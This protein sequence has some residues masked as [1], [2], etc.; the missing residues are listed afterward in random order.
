MSTIL[1]AR[2]GNTFNS[3]DKVVRVGL[4]SDL[5]LS[6]SGSQQ[7]E[8]LGLYINQLHIPITAVFT[9]CLIR[10]IQTA[11]IALQTANIDIPIQQNSIFNEIDYGPD[12]GKTEEEVIARIGSNA[13]DE[14]DNQAIVPPDWQVNPQ[15]IINHWRYFADKIEHQ[16][17]GQT[18]LVVTSNGIARFAPYLTA[19]FLEFTKNYGIKLA[20]GSLSSITKQGEHWAV[21]YWNLKI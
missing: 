13:L 15:R 2:H 17:P 6:K 1:I 9:S 16:Y 19:D 7:A 8:K 21:D 12:E 4:N 11:S 3:G 10:T 18:I 20:T 5:P 14:W